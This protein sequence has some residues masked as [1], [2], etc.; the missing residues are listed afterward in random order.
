AHTYYDANGS[1]F[2]DAGD[3]LVNTRV[4][5][6]SDLGVA[7]AIAHQR[8][9]EDFLVLL[10]AAGLCQD[11]SQALNCP[12]AIILP[13]TLQSLNLQRSGNNV[14]LRWTTLTEMNNRGFYV[15]RLQ[16]SGNW[17]NVTFIPSRATDGNSTGPLSYTF[18]DLN[19]FRGITQYRLRQ[20]DIDGRSRY[21]DIRSTRGDGALSGLLLYP[22]PSRGVT[23][24]QFADAV[25]LRDVQVTD[26][27]GRVVKEWRST[28]SQ[29]LLVA[30]LAPGVY[31][32]RVIDQRDGWQETGR[33]LVSD[34]R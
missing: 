29:S 4:L 3:V 10:D 19:N 1:Q 5:Q 6:Q 7:Q 12:A 24:I 25:G 14:S 28:G 23:H 22:N 34:S 21:S 31:A 15:Q 2:L 11:A 30:D 33:L 8:G 13:V 17:T 9:Q 32:V 27:N 26:M 18:S 20:V 16:G